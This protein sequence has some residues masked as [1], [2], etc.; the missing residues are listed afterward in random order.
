MEVISYQVL[1]VRGGG[2][3]GAVHR[4]YGCRN[5]IFFL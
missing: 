5:K 1:G 3:M 4:N 2:V